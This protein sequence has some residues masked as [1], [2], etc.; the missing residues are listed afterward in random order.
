MEGTALGLF[1]IKK[2]RNLRHASRLWNASSRTEIRARSFG[3][4]LAKCHTLAFYAVPPLKLEEEEAMRRALIMIFGGLVA[5]ALF[6]ALVHA[7]LVAAHL[8]T[9]AATTVQGLTPRRV[10]ASVAIAL[11]LAGVIAGSMS[12]VRAARRIGNRGRKGAI[13]ALV[14]GVLAV[15]NGGLNLAVATGGPG[16]G[17][18]VVGGAAAFVLGLIG[19]AMGGLN[20]FR[21]R[22]RVLQS[23]QAM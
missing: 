22:R 11:G 3:D 7:V 4:C 15:I 21:S 6:V 8:S 23:E 16:S 9:S 10:W 17:N 18:G 20:L 12:L 13:V 1:S 14:T 19:M 2:R 5:A